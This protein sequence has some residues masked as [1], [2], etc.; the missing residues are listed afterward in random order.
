MYRDYIL[1]FIYTLFTCFMANLRAKNDLSNWIS[2]CFTTVSKKETS[3]FPKR[4]TLFHR[5]K[6]NVSIV[7]IPVKQWFLWVENASWMRRKDGFNPSECIDDKRNKG[8][9]HPLS[10]FLSVSYKENVGMYSWNE[11]SQWEKLQ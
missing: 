1:T 3:C 11:N 9:I 2:A 7:T 5:G 6:Q 10:N 4:N 8:T